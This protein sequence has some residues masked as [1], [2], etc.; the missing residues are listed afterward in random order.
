MRE[1]RETVSYVLA[2]PP[3][4]VFRGCQQNGKENKIE[5]GW[6]IVQQNGD[7]FRKKSGVHGC[8]VANGV[9]MQSDGM[10]CGTRGMEAGMDGRQLGPH[11]EKTHVPNWCLLALMTRVTRYYSL[12]NV[13]AL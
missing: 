3:F 2:T 9:Y 11:K 10:P 1:E 5:A 6:L 8:H 13:C 7:L 4:I 12:V